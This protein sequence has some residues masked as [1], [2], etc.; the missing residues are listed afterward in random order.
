MSTTEELHAALE[1]VG[2]GNAV[3]LK[4]TDGREVRGVLSDNDDERVVLD[5]VDPDEIADG[6]E[7][8]IALADVDQVLVDFTSEGPE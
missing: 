8:G 5:D 6:E 2:A 3:R 7:H 4:L 1:K